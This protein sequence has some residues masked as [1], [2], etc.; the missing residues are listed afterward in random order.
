MLLIKLKRLGKFAGRKSFQCAKKF[1]NE[2]AVLRKN[3]R[4]SF[5][6]LNKYRVFILERALRNSLISDPIFSDKQNFYTGDK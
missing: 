1:A 4:A 6:N 2:F 3:S 5:T